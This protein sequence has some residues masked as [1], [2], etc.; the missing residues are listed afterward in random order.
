MFLR[1]QK[2]QLKFE[3]GSMIVGIVGDRGSGKTLLQVFFL[4]K[5]FQANRQIYSNFHLKFKYTL[6]DLKILLEHIKVKAQLYNAT[7]AIDEIH[8]FFEARRSMS[9]KNIVGSYL[10]TQSRK[11]SLDIYYT[12]QYFYQ[13]DKRIR[14]NTDYL[15]RAQK[16][17]DD[18]YHYIL[19]KKSI[20]ITLE[21]GD[22]EKI[23]EFFLRG[24]NAK[25]YY[26]LYDTEEIIMDLGDGN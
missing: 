7:L 18:F 25:K 13:V 24:R 26:E 2:I 6:L 5:D 1:K 21:A 9:K 12:T 14:D 16:I 4:H 20:S 23:N 15:I 17:D 11:R 10:T 8:V 3:C 19:Y 22:Y